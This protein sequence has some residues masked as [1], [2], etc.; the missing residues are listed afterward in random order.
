MENWRDIV[1]SGM[2]VNREYLDDLRVGDKVTFDVDFTPDT[3]TT[4]ERMFGCCTSFSCDTCGRKLSIAE[5]DVPETMWWR[6]PKEIPNDRT[7]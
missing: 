6:N 7:A 4:I 5:K 1:G 2:A 3:R